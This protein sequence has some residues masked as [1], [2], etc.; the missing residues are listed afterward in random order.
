MKKNPPKRETPKAPLGRTVVQKLR[1]LVGQSM[2]AGIP[3]QSMGR[4]GETL[5]NRSARDHKASTNGC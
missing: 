2:T 5:Y 4:A 1:R 3:L